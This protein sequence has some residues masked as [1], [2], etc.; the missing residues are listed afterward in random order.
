MHAVDAS[1]SSI[2]GSTAAGL[3][4]VL[5][6][7]VIAAHLLHK[8]NALKLLSRGQKWVLPVL[9]KDPGANQTPPRAQETETKFQNDQIYDIA[10]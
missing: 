4:A 5:L 10:G 9:R 8:E 1:L 7:G 3:C 2:L 6:I